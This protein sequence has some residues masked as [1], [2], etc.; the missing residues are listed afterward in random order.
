MHITVTPHQLILVA[1][2]PMP[3]SANRANRAM[4]KERK[5]Y[6]A[7]DYLAGKKPYYPAIRKDTKTAAY[8]E[9][10][11]LRLRCP[12]ENWKSWQEPLLVRALR[13]DS[14]L[15]LEME[16]WEF[17]KD[18]SSDADNRVKELQDIL[19]THLEINDRRIVEGQ[20]HKFV[21]KGCDPHIAVTLCIASQYNRD[22]TLDKL[23]SLM[24]QFL[25]ERVGNYDRSIEQ[26][27]T[28][29]LPAPARSTRAKK[30]GM[31]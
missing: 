31:A 22:K 18:D 13:E 4:V 5:N 24:C 15:L 8:R 9:E 27:A 7:A 14:S 12:G 3:P 23:E 30:R 28:A 21:E 19:A 10:A 16:L 2:M 29:I 11:L 20:Q 17:F 1:K 25:E 6:N 26:T